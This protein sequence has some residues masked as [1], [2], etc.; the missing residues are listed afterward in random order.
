M[1]AGTGTNFQST[2]LLRC[3]ILMT[4]AV[5]LY[6]CSSKSSIADVHVA[7]RGNTGQVQ[8]SWGGRR[9]A[10]HDLFKCALVLLLYCFCIA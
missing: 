5:H 6:R 2:V 8:S 10:P 9:R 1:Q 3:C 4:M 7:E